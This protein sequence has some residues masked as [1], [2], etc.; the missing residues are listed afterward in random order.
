MHKFVFISPPVPLSKSLDDR[1]D[2]MNVRDD[3]E[4]DWKTLPDSDWNDFSAHV[5]QRRW[6]T[7]KR[8][9]KGYEDMT[10]QGLT[11]PYVTEWCSL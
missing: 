3:S 2:S 9:I 11:R 6:L 8:S 1:V 5:L 7:L 10:H 4:I